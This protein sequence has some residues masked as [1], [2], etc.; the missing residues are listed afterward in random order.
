M[1]DTFGK[2]D[3]SRKHYQESFEIAKRLNFPLDYLI[4]EKLNLI[5]NEVK[6]NTA[7]AFV[8]IQKWIE[9]C[10]EL[11]AQ[12]TQ[13]HTST[14]EPDAEPAE[15]IELLFTLGLLYQNVG[16]YYKSM[17]MYERVVNLDYD[18]LLAWLNIG[19][20]FF[21]QRDY[22]KAIEYYSIG[23][24]LTMDKIAEKMRTVPDPLDYS[25][26]AS[27]FH[28]L[29]LTNNLGQSLRESGALRESI[30]IFS[31]G[32]YYSKLVVAMHERIKV[33]SDSTQL[34]RR[35]RAVSTNN[36]YLL[37]TLYTVKGLANSWR[38]ME[39]LEE[40]IFQQIL[41]YQRDTLERFKAHSLGGGSSAT[42]SFLPVNQNENGNS[43]FDPYTLSLFK[44][45]P[46]DLDVFIC[47]QNCPMH[48]ALEEQQDPARFRL[49]DPLAYAATKQ[50]LLRH[51]L[52]L[53]SPDQHTSSQAMSEEEVARG[54]VI[55]VGYLSFDWRDHPMGRLTAGLVTSQEAK[56]GRVEVICF[57]YGY[58]DRSEI[59]AFVEENCLEYVD[60]HA[61]KN[62]YS[63]A[64]R[65]A[66][67]RL[68]MLVDITS[69]TYNNRM[70]ILSF[71]PAPL[72]I[73]YLGFP[74]TTGCRANSFFLLS[75]ADRG[76]GKGEEGEGVSEEDRL[77]L[78]LRYPVPAEFDYSILDR[79]V[80][81]PDYLVQPRT[82]TST[83]RRMR[84]RDGAAEGRGVGMGN[85]SA[86][87][88]RVFSER[89]LLLPFA[90]QANYMPLTVFA[91]SSPAT[92]SSSPSTTTPSSSA[93]GWRRNVCVLNGNKKL[94]PVFLQTLANFLHQLPATSSLTSSADFQVFFLDFPPQAE[95]EIVQQLRFLG[96]HHP[97]PSPSP[98]PKK[99]SRRIHFL[100]REKWTAH[101]V[102]IQRLCDVVLDTF[103]YGGHT[104]SSDVLWMGLPI[105]ALRGF[106]LSRGVRMPSRVAAS[107]LE[108]LDEPAP[109]AQQPRLSL[110]LTHDTVKGYEDGLRRLLALPSAW[111]M[112]V[113]SPSRPRD[114]GALLHEVK[115]RI[116][117]RSCFASIFS[118]QLVGRLFLRGYQAL[119]E[120]HL[121]AASPAASL[122]LLPSPDWAG[123]RFNLVQ[124][125]SSWTPAPPSAWPC[126][127]LEETAEALA[128]RQNGRV[129]FHGR[130]SSLAELTAWDKRLATIP[131]H[132]LGEA[133]RRRLAE[134]RAAL[135]GL[136]LAVFL[137]ELNHTAA[138]GPWDETVLAARV[139]DWLAAA[140]AHSQ[141]PLTELLVD[142]LGPFLQQ[143]EA[144]DFLGLS[145]G[146]R[147]SFLRRLLRAVVDQLAGREDEEAAVEAVGWLYDRT[148]GSFSSL[149]PLSSRLAAELDDWAAGRCFDH[150]ALLGDLAA[151]PWDDIALALEDSEGHGQGREGR[152]LYSVALLK[153]FRCLTAETFERPFSASSFR[154]LAPAPVLLGEG[155]QGLGQWAEEMGEVLAAYRLFLSR[156]LEKPLAP[157][158]PAAAIE[159]RLAELR[160][161]LETAVR[162]QLLR[163]QESF[164]LFEFGLQWSALTFALPLP[165]PD[166]S[167]L[168]GRRLA[169]H[170]FSFLLQAVGNELVTTAKRRA[171]RRLVA[172]RPE[173]EAGAGPRT[174]EEFRRLTRER[175]GA[176]AEVMAANPTVAVYCFEYGQHWWPGWG[177]SSLPASFHRPDFPAH[178][179]GLGPAPAAPAEE[180]GDEPGEGQALGGSEEAVLYL[181]YELAR[182]GVN[183]EIFADL[184]LADRF[185]V[186]YQH[187]HDTVPGEG[188]RPVVGRVSW[189]HYLD[190]DSRRE[191]LDVFVSWRYAI[192]LGLTLLAPPPPSPSPRRLRRF[193]W[194]HDLV[195]MDSL[196]PL[197][198]FFPSPHHPGSWERE[199]EGEDEGP[200]V[201]GYLVQSAFHREFV[202]AEHRRLLPPGPSPSEEVLAVV[203]RRIF[204]LPNGIHP[205]PFV[206]ANPSGADNP[207]DPAVFVY[208]SAPTRGLE[209]VLLLW[210]SIRAALPTARLLVF[211]GFTARGL[212][213]LTEQM[214]ADRFAAWFGHMQRLL[215][216][217]G[218]EYAGAVSHRE[219]YR[220]LAGAGWLLYPSNFAETGCIALVKAMASGA[221]PISSRYQSSVLRELGEEFDLGPWSIPG[222]L[223]A[224]LLPLTNQ[225]HR[226]LTDEILRDPVA[227][228]RWG[229]E[230]YLGSVLAA[231]RWAQE[232]P[233]E[234]RAARRRMIARMSE[235]YR[236]QNSAKRLAAIIEES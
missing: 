3:L 184:P 216:Q 126:Y 61:D 160:R 116:L 83:E 87:F 27:Y 151:L 202:Q 105:V 113:P 135:D 4:T 148:V 12:Y 86:L 227:Y 188:Q 80:A 93:K 209:A 71:Q 217:A 179:F 218:V 140:S 233:E 8:Q 152:Q 163:P 98:S 38:E 56:D 42:S 232:Q 88:F 45:L 144:G 133:D 18:H 13:L 200:L 231:L 73:N 58:H 181:S 31:I 170:F 213:R 224:L 136:R 222:H 44:F 211:Y 195:P 131:P 109:P 204:V 34:S 199:G 157:A 201:A 134:Q 28:L 154:L 153:I 182:R 168:R 101:L 127:C 69:H 65:I 33:A 14:D 60:L 102:R 196:L 198:L 228:D 24:N 62:D 234:M 37:L 89:V 68:D 187:A 6:F 132:W 25:Q 235:R 146:R 78:S 225:S 77:L 121:L 159:G 16:Q 145:P 174:V 103:V 57:G 197:D 84:A 11:R 36:L 173:A 22:G 72:L 15:H 74:G 156:R 147:L 129:T 185:R 114:S 66:G 226:R 137:A 186:S 106:G 230:D 164:G 5:S 85:G 189:L 48:Q 75:G 64:R 47:Q 236:W 35:R 138:D 112:P 205:N 165:S 191:D 20:F 10:E 194:L 70:R 210:P 19:N 39:F 215:G 79:F 171:F 26:R 139:A 117:R 92:P 128:A 95:E 125:R 122:S 212:A 221:L 99:K 162:W 97:V 158:S 82:T 90:Y 118:K 110:L 107:L 2:F 108:N 49:V 175:E 52:A 219:L 23:F 40:L 59:R 111:L 17:K 55:R 67:H 81:P 190:F 21:S 183:V 172:E 220:R 54:K 29:S 142:S 91:H 76:V 150:L 9:E 203:D 155:G 104:T 94:E 192:S 100:G 41:S 1:Y 120:E 30:N 115:R 123:R 124:L 193:L 149:R 214:G 180:E 43:L 208:A 63:I 229:R 176:A 53:N 207:N 96:I 141:R 206:P 7:T 178:F 177:P 223:G 51:L 130:L 143:L 169:G 166:P 167:N 119:H 161:L 32:Y 46:S 50:P